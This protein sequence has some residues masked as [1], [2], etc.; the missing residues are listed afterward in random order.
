MAGA[1]I[2]SVPAVK[3]DAPVNAPVYTTAD[4][5]KFEM[6]YINVDS[7][8][9]EYRN[10]TQIATITDAAYD[11]TVN[12]STYNTYAMLIQANGTYCNKWSGYPAENYNYTMN[13]TR[14]LVKTTLSIAYEEYIK[15]QHWNSSHTVIELTKIYCAPPKASY[16]FPL[17]VGGNWTSD[18][19]TYQPSE[20]I[21]FNETGRLYNST[22][23]SMG[24]ESISYEVAKE[25][26]IGGYSCLNI[27]K[28]GETFG[29]Y[30]STAGCD[31]LT[32]SSN[33]DPDWVYYHMTRLVAGNYNGNPLSGV[34][35]PPGPAIT[36][37]LWNA[38]VPCAAAAALV[39]VL[40]RHKATRPGDSSQ[41]KRERSF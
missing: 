7:T 6:R 35:E 16:S 10:E 5:W 9:A 20:F 37:F 36:E 23:W 28:D 39:L 14:Y 1:A 24:E 32:F 33:F 11:I 27:T 17:T 34:P 18:Y 8:Y 12:G 38:A 40:F 3:A 41:T 26:N 29:Y 13:T 21:T 31:V 30:S 19:T 15:I 4:W 25:E 22:G 2:L